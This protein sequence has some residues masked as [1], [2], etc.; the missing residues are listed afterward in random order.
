MSKVE[1]EL[2]AKK[3]AKLATLKDRK[4]VAELVAEVCEERNP[5]FDR[6]R[7]ILASNAR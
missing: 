6:E 1:F 7:F 5:R 3:I 4:L 2:F